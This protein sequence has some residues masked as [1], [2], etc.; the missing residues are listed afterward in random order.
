MFPNYEVVIFQPWTVTLPHLGYIAY[1]YTFKLGLPSHLFLLSF[2]GSFFSPLSYRL[3]IRSYSL[4]KPSHYSPAPHLLT[5]CKAPPTWTLPVSSTCQP[6]PIVPTP[7][8]CACVCRR[9]PLRCAP[10]FVSLWLH[11]CPC[12]PLGGLPVMIPSAPLCPCLALPELSSEFWH[13]L[14]LG[15]FFGWIFVQGRETREPPLTVSRALFSLILP[16]I[17]HAC[18]VQA[19]W[20][21]PPLPLSPLY[22]PPLFS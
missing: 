14:V 22:L 1:R 9:F 7:A 3:P 6:P 15:I 4:S 16:L 13:R 18:A 11:P 10:S 21:P 8:P 12:Q 5:W 19:T 2:S 17:V 20:I